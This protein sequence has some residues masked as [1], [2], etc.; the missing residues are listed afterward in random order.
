MYLKRLFTELGE[1]GNLDYERLLDCQE[2]C[3][4]TRGEEG[5][6]F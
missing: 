5:L 1:G 4:P 2:I 6:L 3:E